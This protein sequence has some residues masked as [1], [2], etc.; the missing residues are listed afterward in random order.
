MKSASRRL[1]ASI[2]SSAARVRGKVHGMKYQHVLSVDPGFGGTGL[3]Y[4]SGGKPS[5]ARVVKPSTKEVDLVERAWHIASV[6]NNFFFTCRE[7]E[8]HTGAWQAPCVVIEY[9][10]YQEG[11]RGQVSSQTGGVIKLSFLIGVLVASFPRHFVIKLV[12]VRDWK[13]QLPKDVVMRR[14]QHIYGKTCRTIDIKSHAWDAL[15]LG[16]WAME[17][18]WMR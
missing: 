7:M 3:V 11:L 10:E 9:P 16:H 17:Q 12:P 8:E 14:M 13:G 1:R 2:A 6:T 4:W 15:G 18:E 5:A